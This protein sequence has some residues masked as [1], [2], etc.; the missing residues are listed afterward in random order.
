MSKRKGKS[1]LSAKGKKAY[2]TLCAELKVISEANHKEARRRF[3][4]GDAKGVLKA[5]L[6]GAGAEAD[7]RRLGCCWA[8]ESGANR[9]SYRAG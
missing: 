2:R 7:A 8:S 6:A 5:T 9:R 3:A 4:A 1:Q